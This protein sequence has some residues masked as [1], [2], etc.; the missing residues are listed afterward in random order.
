MNMEGE[1]ILILAFLIESEDDKKRFIGLTEE[2]T[3][4]LCLL[5][6]RILYKSDDGK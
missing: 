6:R 1:E 2:Y 4:K 5:E 3:P